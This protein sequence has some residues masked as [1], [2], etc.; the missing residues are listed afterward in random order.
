MNNSK[1][2][3]N[4]NYLTICNHKLILFIN[5]DCR[6]DV[7]CCFFRSCWKAEET[8]CCFCCLMEDF[9]ACY[10]TVCCCFLSCCPAKTHE[11]KHN[12]KQ[13]EGPHS[14]PMIE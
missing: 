14:E 1:R 3:Y 13:H 4:K 7:F 6:M 8:I 2:L 10:R 5:K 9:L 12:H 11:N